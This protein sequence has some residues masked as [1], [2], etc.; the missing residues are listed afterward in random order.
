METWIMGNWEPAA[1]PKGCGSETLRLKPHA[2]FFYSTSGGE[3]G[4]RERGQSGKG[5]VRTYEQKEF[6]VILRMVLGIVI[7]PLRRDMRR[8]CVASYQ[9]ASAVSVLI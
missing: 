9:A 3:R 1:Q 5:S 2:P 7:R 8:K 4:E 6:V